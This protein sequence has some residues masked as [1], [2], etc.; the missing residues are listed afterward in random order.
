MA[1]QQRNIR[2]KLVIFKRITH[3]IVVEIYQT[4]SDIAKTN[5]KSQKILNLMPKKKK[6]L[7][8]SKPRIIE[9]IEKI[10]D[11]SHYTQKRYI[12]ERCY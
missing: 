1:T 9:T 10:Y 5:A 2:E 4:C 3:S 7:E 6:K 12:R 11:Y 8:D